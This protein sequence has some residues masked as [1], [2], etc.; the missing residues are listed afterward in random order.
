[1]NPNHVNHAP[2][3]RPESNVLNCVVELAMI[4]RAMKT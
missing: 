1:M 2:N 4:D 3:A